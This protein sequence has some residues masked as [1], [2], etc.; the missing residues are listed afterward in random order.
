MRWPW[1]RKIASTP[2]CL[3]DA[4]I[5]RIDKTGK[6][7]LFFDPKCKYIWSMAFDHS[8]NLFVATGDSGIIYRVTPDGKGSKFFDTEETH[9]RSM[10]I[11]EAGNLI[12]GTEPSGLVIRITPNGKSF[13]LYQTSKREVTAVAE[14]E[15]LIYAAAVGNRVADLR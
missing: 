10:I 4:K 14:H 15:G 11:D 9:A 6:P 13:V 1:I 2:P 12:V 8:G 7:Q 3:P 5:Y